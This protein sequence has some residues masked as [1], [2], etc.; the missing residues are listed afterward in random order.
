VL[1]KVIMRHLACVLY[2][3]ALGLTG[4]G[5]GGGGGGG[6]GA[7]GSSSGGGAGGAPTLGG[8]A[9]ARQQADLKGSNASAFAEVFRNFIASEVASLDEIVQSFGGEVPVLSL[10]NTQQT[11]PCDDGGSITYTIA[12]NGADTSFQYDSC[13]E[14][15]ITVN[16]RMAMSVTNVN[17]TLRTFDY[18]VTYSSL[19]AS[20]SSGNQTLQGTSTVQTEVVGGVHVHRLVVDQTVMISG[21]IY[22]AEG[23]TVTLRHTPRDYY[24]VAVTAGS[25][26]IGIEGRGF[27]DV[28]FRS[29]TND[30]RLTGSQSSEV[31]VTLD[32]KVYGIR[33]RDVQGQEREVVIPASHIRYVAVL[34]GRNAPPSIEPLIDLTL[35]AGASHVVDLGRHVIDP[36]L[37]PVVTT[38]AVVAGPAGRVLPIAALPSARF[39]IRAGDG[40]VFKVRASAI[41]GSGQ[42]GERD[43]TV[44]VLGDHDRDGI[45]DNYD[46]DDDNDGHPDALDALPFDP[47]ES[48][49]H[50]RDGI[51]DNADTDDDN[52]GVEDAQDAFPLDPACSSASAGNGDECFLSAIDGF[53][54]LIT[55]D[56]VLHFVSLA[57]KTVYRWDSATDIFLAQWQVGTAVP[58][59][60]VAKSVAY[61]RTHGRVYFGFDNGAI[62]AVNTALGAEALFTT[63]PSA[64]DGLADAGN[65]LLAQDASGAWETHYVFAANGAL[66]SSADWNHYSR[67]YAFNPA[68]RRVYFFRDTSSPN[69]LHYEEID[70]ATGLRLSAGETPYHGAYGIVPPIVPS[71]AGDK[72]LLGSGNLFNAGALSWAGA[73]P[74]GIEAAYWDAADGLIA[75]RASGARTAVERRDAAMSVAEQRS[76]DGAPRAIARVS[77]GY[78]VVTE[79]DDRLALH[80][81][82]ASDDSDADGV[83]N[84]NDAFPLD[85]AASID[86]DHDGYPDRW[87]G[88]RSQADS[89]TGLIL[90]AYPT[91]SACYLPQHGD[92]STCNVASTL[93]DYVPDIVV[94]DIDGVVYLLSAENAR[95]YRYSA[96]GAQHL[97]PV[98]VGS[99]T[100]TG[101]APSLMEYAPAQDRLYLGY[102]SGAITYI[103][104]NDAQ[105]RE[106]PFATVATA[107]GGLGAAGDFLAVQDSSGAW[108]THY[109]FDEAGT[110]RGSA[111]W[112]HYSR[113]YE[114]NATLRRLF[115]FRDN[116][117]P[118]DLLY[119][120]I[121][122]NGV[123]EGEGE[124]PYHGSY[125]I[126][127][128]IVMSPDDQFVMLGSGDIYRAADVTWYR[129]LL[130]DFVAAIWD[131]NG[132]ITAVEDVGGSTRI[133]RYDAAQV[134]QSEESRAGTPLALL[135][136][137]GGY[138][139][140]T[141]DGRKPGF[142]PVTR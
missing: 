25:G 126:A 70:Q 93:P 36:D 72:I 14:A 132:T 139:L 97:S 106:R 59:S 140:V 96:A 45:F 28:T 130:T 15:G 137:A 64:V 112:N 88:G 68:E 84:N 78:I 105:L 12:G 63:L 65:F 76:F 131:D 47:T 49:D 4:C 89:T 53:D 6:G 110:L 107:V 85:A 87:N 116:S 33:Y 79:H 118:N 117:S 38:L 120:Q 50:D 20:S 31:L 103:D 100:S 34:D 82:R 26:S 37:E 10:A 69:D 3:G 101:T 74:G 17:A 90:D 39:E 75:L 128:P 77:Q 13:V 7:G 41:D 125:Q 23:L 67:A 9:P 73:V 58:G 48:R 43:F 81:Y 95:I 32:G 40:G 102:G 16:G 61:V 86:T 114:W 66:R 99:G 92:G 83:L 35:N 111:D 19:S 27:A 30:V 60:S 123:I 142:S 71:P 124:T 24:A 22:T 21:A 129:S 109:Y 127:P 42:R 44:T 55:I 11:Q 98:L 108:E 133:H 136:Y 138:L 18:R 141:H 29:S 52:D 119:E 122:P 134:W 62:T 51:G 46:T 113:D 115:F 135:K 121:G 94:G 104:L 5:G 54:E 56:G 91:E 80:R 8:V 1:G 2:L 57:D